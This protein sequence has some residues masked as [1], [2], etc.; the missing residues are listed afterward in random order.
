MSLETVH[1]SGKEKGLADSLSRNDT[2][3]FISQIP[4]AQET[5]VANPPAV[6]ELLMK[7]HPGWTSKTWTAL[8]GDILQKA[9]RLY[10]EILQ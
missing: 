2:A 7:Q 5:L 8:W 10:T 9:C 6:E 1:I 3:S 4:Y